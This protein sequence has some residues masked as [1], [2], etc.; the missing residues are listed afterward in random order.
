[1]IATTTGW[2]WDYIGQNLT[3]PRVYALMEY[4]RKHPPTH[5]LVAAYLGVKSDSPADDDLLGDESD[6]GGLVG[7]LAGAGSVILG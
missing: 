4:W 3:L 1:M 5:I 6:L 2:T 7:D